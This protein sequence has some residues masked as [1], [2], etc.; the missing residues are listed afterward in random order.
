MKR[1]ILS[2][3]AVMGLCAIAM[4]VPYEAPS[5]L[6][7]AAGGIGNAIG[8]LSALT[9][10]AIGA[11][12]GRTLASRAVQQMSPADFKLASDLDD[13]ASFQRAI[14]W[15]LAATG[16]RPG[17]GSRV[18]NVPCGNYTISG[19]LTADVNGQNLAVIGQSPD[20]VQIT[21]TADADGF[22][23]TV[24]STS[25]NMTQSGVD[26]RNLSLDMWAPT[27]M[28][29]T[30]RAY[31][32]IGNEST[33]QVGAN[34]ILKNLN[35]QSGSNTQY[36]GYGL[37][38]T[39][40]ADNVAC[41][42]INGSTPAGSTIN[43]YFSGTYGSPQGQFITGVNCRDVWTSGGSIGLQ[44]GDWWQG[45]HFTN[46]NMGNVAQGLVVGSPTLGSALNVELQIRDSYIM[47]TTMI[48]SPSTAGA[49]LSHVTITGTVFDASALTGAVTAVTIGTANGGGVTGINFSGNRII[50]RPN[51]ANQTGLL[52]L[53]SIATGQFINNSI[54]SYN[55]T[56]SIAVNAQNTTYGV[57]FI[58]NVL[59]NNTNSFVDTASVNNFYVGN[60]INAT[61]YLV[62][63]GNSKDALVV[64]TFGDGGNTAYFGLT[65]PD[66]SV[67]YLFYTKGMPGVNYRFR[68]GNQNEILDLIDAGSGTTNCGFKMTGALAGSAPLLGNTCGG[69]VKVSTPPVLQN[70]TVSTLP[71]CTS[72]SAGA[73]TYVTDVASVSAGGVLTGGGSAKLFAVCNGSNWVPSGSL[74]GDMTATSY[75][76]SGPAPTISGSCSPGAAVGGT[77]AQFTLGA[78]C[79]GQTVVVTFARTATNG[80][81]CWARNNTTSANVSLRYVSTTAINLFPN[82]SAGDV[83]NFG[84]T[85][86]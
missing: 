72:A 86:Y 75:G 11:L 55:G 33:G 8:D 78:A 34:V 73:I 59:M 51:T 28:S 21:Q 17:N 13:T 19:A 80:W 82:G 39:N 4:A 58:G 16:P 31:A 56:G 65:G 1:W 2:V 70:Y 37:Y 23:V 71:A 54:G 61:K 63:D 60:S 48:N 85:P 64:S 22:A 40:I 12:T 46:L 20:C 45:L 29:T 68:D 36:W 49:S 74:Q 62:G 52:L 32:I 27:T 67:S 44:I 25:G 5:I 76:V 66:T 43:L 35:Y 14:A 9:S 15:A 81:G 57:D 42:N 7:V 84:C 77:T 50:G 53:G 38:V 41:D 69:F 10:R 18:I 6:S 47:G 26:L 30:R 24:E 83:I 3:V 79:T